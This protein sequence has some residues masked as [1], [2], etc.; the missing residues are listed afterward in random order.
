MKPPTKWITNPTKNV[1]VTTYS[2][3]AVLYSSAT[4][5]YVSPTVGNNEQNKPATVWTPTASA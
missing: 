4:Q 2:N 1:N 5:N 3:A